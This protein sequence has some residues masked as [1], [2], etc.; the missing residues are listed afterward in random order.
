MKSLKIISGIVAVMALNSCHSQLPGRIE[1][2][3]SDVEDE[4]ATWTD[5]DWTK[6]Q[7]DFE[8]LMEEY[9]CNYDSYSQEEKDAINKAIGRYNGLL[10]RQGL[11]NVYNMV[12]EF[13]KQFPSFLDGFVSAFKTDETEK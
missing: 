3:V 6:S 11:E 7:D 2:Y 12:D 8:K 1:N 5:Y 4:S 10:I 13:S 9:E